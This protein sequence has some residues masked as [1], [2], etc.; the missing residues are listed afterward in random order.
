[1][2]RRPGQNDNQPRHS[3]AQ[4]VVGMA[5]LG[6]VVAYPSFKNLTAEDSPE[7]ER[8]NAGTKAFS[9]IQGEPTRQQVYAYYNALAH[10][11]RSERPALATEFLVSEA[12]RRGD[13]DVANIAVLY[14]LDHATGR[15]LIKILKDMDLRVHGYLRSQGPDLTRDVRLRLDQCQSK[16]EGSAYN[17]APGL[18]LVVDT[19][20]SDSLVT[21]FNCKEQGR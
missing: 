17:W 13:H 2:I 20:F 19:Y 12:S 10:G 5:F 11:Q 8:M 4:V 6:L 16:L 18:D 21:P 1:M 14:A 3:F 15:E 7:L 9:N